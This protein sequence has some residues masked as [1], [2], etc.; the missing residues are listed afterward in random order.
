MPAKQACLEANVWKWKALQKGICP[1]EEDI[2]I[3][4]GAGDAWK[5]FVWHI[6]EEAETLMF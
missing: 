3:S 5:P 6:E 2:L 4:V 1:V